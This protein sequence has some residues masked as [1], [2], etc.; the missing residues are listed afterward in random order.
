ML[1]RRA[2]DVLSILAEAA[3]DDDDDHIAHDGGQV[4]VGCERLRHSTLAQL[5]AVCAVS[6]Q[7]FGGSVRRYAINGTGRAILRR[8]QLALEVAAALRAGRGG[9]KVDAFDRLMSIS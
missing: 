8:P 9:F 7:D 2:L 3:P 6:E 1:T 4:W 5:L